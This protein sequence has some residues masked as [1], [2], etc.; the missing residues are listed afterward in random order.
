MR[1]KYAC[2]HC[3]GSGAEQR[4][5]VRVAPAAAALIRKGVASEGL[6]AFIATAKFCDAL[7]L[8]RQ[9]QQFAR[10]GVA[11]SRRTMADWM[12][13]AAGA[14]RPLLAALGDQLRGGPVLQIDE[15]AVQVLDEP[16]RANTTRSYVW[17]ARGE[18]PTAPVVVVC[19]GMSRAGPHGWR[20]R[21]AGRVLPPCAPTCGQSQSSAM[22]FLVTGVAGFIGFHLAAGWWIRVTM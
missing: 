16:G 11:V 7:P 3:E 13:A 15:T 21:P 9:E 14:C 1:P 4:A 6:L 5:A 22:K 18:P 17:V 20:V 19:T 8:Y 2:H 10:L 12:L